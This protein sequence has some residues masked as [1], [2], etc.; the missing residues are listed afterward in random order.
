MSWQAV[1][2]ILG[3][4]WAVATIIAVAGWVST[5]DKDSQDGV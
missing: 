4:V 3:I 5:Y 2:L 1:V